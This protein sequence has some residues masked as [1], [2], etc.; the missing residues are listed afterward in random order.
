MT[1]RPPRDTPSGMP[2][3]VLH[4]WEISPFCG[5]VRRVLAYK[6]LE[7][8]VTNYNGLE[9]RKAAKLTPVG[10]LPVLDYDGE[11]IAD[12]TS[13]ASFLEQRHPEPPLYPADARDRAL[14]HVFEDW[15]DESLYWFE[16]YL[17]FSYPEVKRR[18][19]ELLCE[20]R[21]AVERALFGVVVGRIYPPKLRA[22]GIGRLPHAEGERRFLEHVDH[23]NALLEGRK[24]LVGEAQS[25]ADIAVVSQLAEVMRTHPIGKKIQ[26]RAH[27]RAWLER[28]GG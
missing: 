2:H 6:G 8:S 23:L 12:S 21:P 18:A 16:V 5:K 26:E 19:V 22:Q 13:I 24:F 17:R 20:G 4:Q 7:F 25:I 14:A 28:V 27:V 10:K 9:A 15:A 11:R 3:I 1:A